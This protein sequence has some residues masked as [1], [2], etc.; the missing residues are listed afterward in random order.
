MIKAANTEHYEAIIGIYNQAV[1]TGVQTADID[2]ITVDEKKAW[3]E[4]V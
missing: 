4:S 1:L 2:E 3:L